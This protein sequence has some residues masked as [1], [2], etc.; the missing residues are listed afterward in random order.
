LSALL[1][2]AQNCDCDVSK[3]R[4]PGDVHLCITHTTSVF[5]DDIIM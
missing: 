4:R 3:H 2:N 5:E 1:A